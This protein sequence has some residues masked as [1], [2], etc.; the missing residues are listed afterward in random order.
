MQLAPNVT[1]ALL[2][3]WARLLLSLALLAHASV[4]ADHAHDQQERLQLQ[5]ASTM[6]SAAPSLS[7]PPVQL[8][9]QKPQDMLGPQLQYWVDAS[10][11][12]PLTQ[13]LQLPSADFHT[14]EPGS[15]HAL[16]GKALWVRFS[17]FNQDPSQSWYLELLAPM[18]DKATLY[19]R[20]S[21]GQWS[22]QQSGD[23]L[24]NKLWSQ[25]GRLPTFKLGSDN[26]QYYLRIEHARLPISV[27]LA[28]HSEASLRHANEQENLL[29]GCYFGLALLV[30]V[31]ALIYA[32]AHRDAGFASFALY[33]SVLSLS[34]LTST[35][36][37]QQ[38]LWPWA[39]RWN[40]TANFL[41]PLL[42]LASG[43]WFIRT[44][45][46]PRKL[47]PSLSNSLVLLALLVTA[48]ALIDA[49]L[50]TRL[51]F[52]LAQSVMLAGLLL[53]SVV[54][55]LSFRRGDHNMRVL[56]T[57]LLPMVLAALVPVLRNL[58][59][60]SAG[61]LTQYAVITGTALQ[62][63][64]LFYALLQR[65]QRAHE[66]RA[67]AQGMQQ[68]EPLTGL[69]NARS[70]MQQLHGS[71]TR[72]SRYQHRFALLLVELTNLKW[73]NKEHGRQV[74]DR[75][76][77]LTATRLRSVARDVD[78]VARLENNQ[79][80][81]LLEGPVSNAQAVEAAT[82]L[83]ARS[84][85]PSD[86]LPVGAGLKLQITMTMMP[87]AKASEAFGEDAHAYLD[88]LLSEAAALDA[89]PRKTIRTLNF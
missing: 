51:G 38:Y 78:T 81:L 3:V 30:V 71:L 17:T 37:A 28:L 69:T 89:N 6:L 75:A 13:V 49:L 47:L 24:P 27:P 67:R 77:V 60:L 10:G 80:A 86:L 7:A 22:A 59:W 68:T 43:L 84:L 36:L 87:D 42:T 83:I 31:L 48:V 55:M 32:R 15:I 79:F 52:T 53:V 63:P 72:A 25:P 41:L 23:A 50:P 26:A 62:T 12:L 33:M 35:G 14:L 2:G 61:W 54:L 40:I 34:Q 21:S 11:Q 82:Q 65:T 46:Q 66:A 70:F 64:L 19:E 29:L 39:G 57:A 76:L 44:V 85:R 8:S 18:L 56:A 58:G 5:A 88:W 73:F 1:Q 16:H 74:G 45:I 9:A 4:W 20:S